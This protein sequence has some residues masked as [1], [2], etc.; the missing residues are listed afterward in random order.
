M[1]YGSGIHLQTVN[2]EE[3]EIEREEFIW[4]RFQ[5]VTFVMHEHILICMFDY[6]S[7]DVN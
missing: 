7:K 5:D 1:I 2:A 4:K 3:T 6:E